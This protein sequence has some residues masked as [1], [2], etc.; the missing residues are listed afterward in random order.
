MK[1]RKWSEELTVLS[2][3]Q[4]FWERKLLLGWEIKTPAGWKRSALPSF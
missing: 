1:G 2:A 3:R 4:V